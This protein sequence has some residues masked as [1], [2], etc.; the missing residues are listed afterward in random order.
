MVVVY[1][2]G[3]S[4]GGVAAVPT[5]SAAPVAEAM[6]EEKVEERGI[7]WGQF[8][9]IDFNCNS[10]CQDSKYTLCFEP[11]ERKKWICYLERKEKKFPKKK[12]NDVQCLELLYTE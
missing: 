3:G 9:F 5:A 7:W 6:K 2:G 10:D 1:G 11:K 12:P 8:I 4:S